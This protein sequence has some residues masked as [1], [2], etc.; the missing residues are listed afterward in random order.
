[1]DNNDSLVSTESCSYNEYEYVFISLQKLVYLQIY[2]KFLL[3]LICIFK[4]IVS[5]KKIFKELS[6]FSDIPHWVDRSLAHLCHCHSNES[7]P[8]DEFNLVIK[9]KHHPPHVCVNGLLKFS[10]WWSLSKYSV[11]W[12][13][14][15]I[16]V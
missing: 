9:M 15:Q 14:Y 13:L 16:Y 4:L 10:Y 7:P 1:M 5:N 6:N 11:I 12:R 2:P 3:R 8:G